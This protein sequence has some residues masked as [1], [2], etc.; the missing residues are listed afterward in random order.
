LLSQAQ[1]LVIAFFSGEINAFG[2][3]PAA[4]STAVAAEAD[5]HIQPGQ[6]ASLRGEPTPT[7]G[8]GLG[9]LA[10]LAHAPD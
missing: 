2:H 10:T 3:K 7:A 1:L 5:A 8:K 9:T 6:Q 4:A